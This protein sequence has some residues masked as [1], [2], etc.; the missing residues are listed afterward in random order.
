MV[1]RAE[2]LAPRPPACRDH[3]DCPVVL[4][5]PVRRAWMAYPDTRG[6]LEKRETSVEVAGSAKKEERAKRVFRVLTVRQ[7][8]RANP[9][10]PDPRDHLAYP[11]LTGHPDPR[12]RLAFRGHPDEK[13]PPVYRE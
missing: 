13:A 10:Y 6:R 7:A 11:G 1:V 3:P 4:V 8:G 12:G 2:C 9:A 5:D